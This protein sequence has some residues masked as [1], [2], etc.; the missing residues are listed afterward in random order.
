MKA[1]RQDNAPYRTI[2]RLISKG[3]G[4]M[5]RLVLGTIAILATTG[6]SAHAESNG[7]KIGVLNDQSSA[8]AAI[9][10]KEVVSA[11]Q[12]AIDDFGGFVLGKPIEL[13]SAD[14]ENSAEIGLAI[15]SE[16]LEKDDVDVIADMPNSAIS[17]DVNALIGKEQKLGLFVSPLTD[18]STEEDCNGHVVAWAFDAHSMVNAT[19]KAL[20]DQGH[21]AFFILSSE[22]EAGR[23]EEEAVSTAL[24]QRGGE[25][26]GKARAAFGAKDFSASLQQAQSAGATEIIMNLAGSDLIAAMKQYRDMG[27]A[28]KDIEVSVVFLH[29]ADVRAIGAETL[30]GL[31]F[32][33]P[34]FW[35]K[36]EASR[37]WGHRMMAIT[38]HAPGWI[39]AG[40][41]S[42]VTNYLNA[43]KKAGTDDA[44][45]VLDVMDDAPIVD[46]FVQNGT[47]YPNGR[48][49]HD[50][51]L[52]EVKKPGDI[53]EPEDYLKLV[54]TVPASE[55][56][57]P[58]SQSD[59]KLR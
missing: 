23:I 43:V 6:P 45:A 40:T 5:I 51:Y 56:F 26:A 13:V 29:Q 10:G 1:T 33:T 2:H 36:D 42:A 46:F 58:Y 25:I 32:S 11:V 19:V 24:L 31:P 52:V 37:Q 21:E 41:Y 30:Q 7:V 34:W 53:A 39:A 47:L 50:M 59:C 9:G 17:L 49:I 38:G 3:E 12:L 54:A 57:R 35:D 27:L 8:Y 55:A 18:R 22:T 28:A 15:A 4:S 48:L 20:L 44:A 16:W 14:H